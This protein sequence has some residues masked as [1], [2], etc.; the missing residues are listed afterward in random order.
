M[1]P[2]C[3]LHGNDFRSRLQPILVLAMFVTGQHCH[4]CPGRC[5]R[6][7][8]NAQ[9][10]IVQNGIDF[11]RS[12]PNTISYR[13][14][15]RRADWDFDFVAPIVHVATEG[16]KC[17]PR[18]EKSGCNGTSW[19]TR[20][21]KV[22]SALLAPFLVCSMF[23]IACFDRSTFTISIVV[24]ARPI[25]KLKPQPMWRKQVQALR[26]QPVTSIHW[27]QTRG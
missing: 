12:G 14:F 6:I 3:S 15:D 9:H 2:D 18:N 11:D 5:H 7:R 21:L 16:T 13:I 24:V 19:R 4:C 25:P 8:I 22:P 20:E 27:H 1:A 10:Y 26:Q 23:R 17:R